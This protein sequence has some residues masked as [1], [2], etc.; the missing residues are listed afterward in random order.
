[1]PT[2][3]RAFVDYDLDL[4]KVIA[5]QWDI[6][7][8]ASDRGV[9]AEELAAALA[10]RDSVS[11][12]WSHLSEDEHQALYDLIIHEGRIPFAH[13]T[14]RYGEIRPM[15]PARR[16]REKPWLSP[17]G[18][19]EALYYRGLI[20]RAFEQTPVGAQ[21]H[22]V[23]P[24]DILEYLPQPEPGMITAAP[25]N[26]VAPPRRIEGGQSS[27]ADD[28]ATLL[29]F[30]LV[31]NAN[32]REWITAEPVERIDRHLRR[33]S[34][35]YRTML[36]SL[37]YDLGLIADEEFLTQVSTVVNKDM[38]RP[39]LEAP[40]LHQLRSLAEAW[41][42]SATWNDLMFTPGLDAD[43]WPNDPRLA[44]QVIIETLQ[45]VPAEIWWSTDSLVEYIKET[46]PDF[47]RPGGDYASWY[48]R[49]SYTGEILHGFEYWDYIEGGLIR[50]I[51]EGPMRWLGLVRSAPGA[52]LLT[53]LGLALVRNENW[54]S[55][56]DPG[57]RVS[58]DEQG[59]VSIPAKVGRYER[60][61]VARFT[62]WMTPPSISV[63]RPDRD[64]SGEGVYLYRLTPQALSRVSDEG[65]SI[66]SHILP[67]LQRLS[68]QNLPANVVKMLEAWHTRP[69]EVVIQDAVILAARDISVYERIR[70]NARISRWLGQQV[71][72]QAYAVQRENLAPLLNAIRGMGLLPLFEA[73]EKDDWP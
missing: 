13:F 11:T 40:R 52:F 46:N 21:E 31:R 22:I 37:L 44:R 60:V 24:S 65:I 16:E 39:W 36:T 8:A 3:V 55:E 32:A 58:I 12:M 10:Q 72:P 49:D 62:A 26:P 19:A 7:L 69:G 61:Q 63:D 1:M 6:D 2:L 54:P 42:I 28:A 5:D 43:R 35:G 45:N 50:F 30:L 20:A 47:Q 41:V 71:G 23:I 51:L 48:L 15:G 38:S 53:P 59:V 57:G 68:G 34:P 33:T 4:L 64:L 9:A 29:A 27:I 17:V 56:A 66:P 73:H 25:G 70:S 67:F 14:R 18:I